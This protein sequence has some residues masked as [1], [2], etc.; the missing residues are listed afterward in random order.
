MMALIGKIFNY[1][2][3]QRARKMDLRLEAVK[4]QLKRDPCNGQLHRQLAETYQQK[5][6]WV[7][8]W[9]ALRSSL[10]LDEKHSE[11]GRNLDIIN[12]NISALDATA[13]NHNLYYRHAT[14][15][16]HCRNLFPDTDFSLL[17]V[18]GGEGW[19]CYFLPHCRYMLADPSFNGIDWA[20]LPSDPDRFEVV[21]ACHVLEHIPVTEREHFLDKLCSMASKYVLLLNPFA[22]PGTWEKERLE[23]A[24]E[25]TGYDWVQEHLNCTLP[26]L[27][28]IKD[29]TAARGYP[30][31]VL[32]NGS[33]TTSLALV[34]LEYFAKRGKAKEVARINR[35]L[36]SRFS[37][38]MTHR[39]YPNAYLV[40]IQVDKN[41]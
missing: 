3:R 10:F 40:E 37:D 16:G 36:N 15:A 2:A 24:L 4:A 19:L 30:T 8:A 32:P 34:F 14:L 23:L 17:D 28:W 13:L 38:L 25:I 39:Q 12:Q 29:V 6:Q 26:Q 9:A 21:V 22:L 31:T 41:G 27:G 1:P 18:G 11:T 7:T 20:N 35:F 33:L 5:E